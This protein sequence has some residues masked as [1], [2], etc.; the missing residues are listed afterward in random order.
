MVQ[1]KSVTRK[2]LTKGKTPNRTKRAKTVK[3]GPGT[4]VA[5][6]LRWKY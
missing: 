2:G 6:A 1:K 5:T 4:S 3:V